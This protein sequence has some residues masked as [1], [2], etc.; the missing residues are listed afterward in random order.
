MALPSADPPNLIW[1]I[2]AKGDT[3]AAH[4]SPDASAARRCTSPAR[5]TVTPQMQHVAEREQLPAELVRD[6]VA[7]G[8]MVI[9][10]NVH[11]AALDPMA[12][13]IKAR[14]KINANIGNSPTTSSLD[15]E[16]DKLRSRRALG[17]RHCDGPLDRQAHRRD[18]RRRS[19]TPPPCRSAPCRSTRRW[20]GVKHAE[21]LTAERAARGDR[22]PGAPG[23]R[24]HDDPRRRAARAP[25]ALPAPRHRDRLARRRPARALDGPPQAENPLYERFDECS[26]SAASTTSRSRSATGCGRARSPTPATPRS[27]PSSTRSAS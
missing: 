20:S 24:L 6:E 2:P 8:R 3:C 19:S 14:V 11:H 17:R 4:R 18:A 12:I 27:S 15:E 10:A 7:R 22:A 25:A 23:R 1:L 16:V 26:R 9:P 21:D 5:A 13:G